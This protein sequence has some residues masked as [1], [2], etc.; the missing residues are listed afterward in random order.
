[1]RESWHSHWF[2]EA[3]D[4]S[5]VLLEVL[6]DICRASVHD[7]MSCPSLQGSIHGVLWRKYLIILHTQT[8]GINL[9]CISSL[10][11]LS[12]SKRARVKSFASNGRKS[13]IPSPIPIKRTGKPSCFARAKITP[14]FAVPSNLVR[15]K[16]VTPTDFWN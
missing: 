2:Q 12:L 11:Q 9:F 13:L 6:L 1:M 3:T 15:V 5:K 8:A 16:P 7:R 4:S 10:Y 14:P